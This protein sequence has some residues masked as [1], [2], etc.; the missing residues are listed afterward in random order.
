MHFGN[1]PL[2]LTEDIERLQC[3][4]KVQEIREKLKGEIKNL[5]MAYSIHKT[6]RPDLKSRKRIVNLVSNLLVKV[7]INKDFIHMLPM[8]E[9]SLFERLK[10]YNLSCD[11][12]ENENEY[13]LK[14]W[15]EKPG[16]FGL[17]EELIRMLLDEAEK[18]EVENAERVQVGEPTTRIKTDGDF[19]DNKKLTGISTK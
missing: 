11:P 15:N 10:D 6:T 18:K 7:A 3:S 12:I 2:N 19:W 9:A 5:V 1:R 14:V 8:V 13:I 4:E 17:V 16:K